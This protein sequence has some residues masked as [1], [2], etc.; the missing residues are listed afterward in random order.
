MNWLQ[1]KV[2]DG[3]YGS[4]SHGISQLIRDAIRQE[5]KKENER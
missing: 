2:D 1:K 4:I 3:D 5:E